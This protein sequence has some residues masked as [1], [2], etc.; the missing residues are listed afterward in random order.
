MDAESLDAFFFPQMFAPL[1]SVD[2]DGQYANTTVSEINVMGTP[3]VNL[4]GG[5]YADGSPF[6]VAF[7]GEPFS[8]A[9]LLGLAYDFE[10]ATELRVEPTLVRKPQSPRLRPST[11]GSLIPKISG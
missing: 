9:K 8:E 4:A 11:P 3:S 1:P 7:L 10:Q 6:S 5:Y 2:G